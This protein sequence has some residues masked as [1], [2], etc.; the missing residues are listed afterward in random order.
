MQKFILLLLCIQ[1]IYGGASDHKYFVMKKK[2]Y[3]YHEHNMEEKSLQTVKNFLKEYPDSIKGRNLLAVF[4]YWQGATNKAKI[5]LENILSSND[6]KP[7]KNLLA[8]IN[9]SSVQKNPTR[10]SIKYDLSHDLASL[11]QDIQA[12]AHNIVDRKYLAHYY[13]SINDQKRAQK[14]ALEVL[15]INPDDVDMLS[16]VKEKPMNSTNLYTDVQR[17]KIMDILD[18][19]YK[20][21]AYQ[22]Y[23]NLY[24]ALNDN[25]EYIPTYVHLNA[26]E[27]AIE[28]KAY[29]IAKK[30][31]I[32]N[33]FPKSSYLTQIKQLIDQKISYASLDIFQD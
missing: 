29:K 33:N 1:F 23:L 30:I 5:I 4:Y 14:M 22:R 17:D 20:D 32:E 27:V 2:A 19:H 15:A 18:H 13:I 26:L 28:V 10:A 21:K 8:K 7:A 24:T 6:Y 12:D 9:A 25:L 16:I 31:L 11:L 3:Y